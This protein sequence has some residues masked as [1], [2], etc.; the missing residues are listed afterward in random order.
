MAV[1]VSGPIEFDEKASADANHKKFSGTSSS[2]SKV[3]R[4][5]C[6]HPGI[7]SCLEEFSGGDHSCE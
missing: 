6:G 2:T 1:C 4:M 5:E 3:I 7:C